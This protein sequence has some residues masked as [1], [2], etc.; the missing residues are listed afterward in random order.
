M[1]NIDVFFIGL[2]DEPKNGY[3]DDLDGVTQAVDALD[4]EEEYIIRKESMDELK[5]K[6]LPEF[7]GF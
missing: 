1:P 4:Y 3:Y 6:N 2:P 5:F 7:M